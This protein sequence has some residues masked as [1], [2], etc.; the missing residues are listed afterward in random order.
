[1]KVHYFTIFSSTCCEAMFTSLPGIKENQFEIVKA[2]QQEFVARAT[3]VTD[4]DG[5]GTFNVWEVDKNGIPREVI[6]D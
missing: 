5:D 4:F 1:M 2:S 6:P 3:A